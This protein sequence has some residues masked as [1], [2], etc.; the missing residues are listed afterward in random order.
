MDSLNFGAAAF[1]TVLPVF[2]AA[3][4]ASNEDTG[5]VLSVVF[6]SQRDT[7]FLLVIDGGSFGEIARVK[8]PQHIIPFGFHGQFFKQQ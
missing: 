4:F 2:V 3:P 7:S 6:D 8:L 5:A 1:F